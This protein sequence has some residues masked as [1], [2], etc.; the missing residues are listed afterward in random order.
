MLLLLPLLFAQFVIL[1]WKKNH[2]GKYH[3]CSL[4]GLWI[5]PSSIGVYLNNWRFVAFCSVFTMQAG[6]VLYLTRRRPINADDPQFIY[7]IF[8]VVHRLTFGLAS[9]GAVLLVVSSFFAL[10]PLRPNLFYWFLMEGSL[11]LF[12]GGYFG[13]MQN[14][15]VQV[16]GESVSKIVASQIVIT[17]PEAILLLNACGLC[18]RELQE[19]KERKLFKLGECGHEF[20]DECIRGWSVLGKRNVCPVCNETCDTTSILSSS[21]WMRSSELWREFLDILRMVLVWNPLIF[22]AATFAIKITGLELFDRVYF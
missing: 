13:V 1:W 5:F 21:P 8:L 11:F 22:I 14:D 18:G 17:R 15:F 19:F 7:R 12:Y 4:V 20:H 10:V 2:P 16:V 6:Y 3:T 9:L